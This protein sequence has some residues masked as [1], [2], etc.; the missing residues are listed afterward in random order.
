MATTLRIDSFHDSNILE[1]TELSLDYV[2]ATTAIKVRS[3]AG[4]EVGQPIYV[5][6]LSREGVEKAVIA[7]ITDETTIG[8]TQALKLPHARYEPVTAVLGDSIHI[9]RAA[10]VDGT[11]PA[12]GQFTVLTTRTI[13]PDQISAYYRDSTGSS[14]FWY[15]YTYFNAVTLEETPLQ[16]FDA[17]RGDDFTHYASLSEIRNEAGF[18]HA[19]NLGD[20]DIEQQRRAAETEINA[21]LSG[22]YTVPFSPVPGRVRTLTIQLASALLLAN[23]YGDTSS[24]RQKLKDARAAIDS[25]RLGATV[26][27]DDAGTALSTSESISGFPGDPDRDAPRSFRMSDRF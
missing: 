10:N 7:A 19:T 20:S 21:A 26:L 17:F 5:G 14:A 15:R 1:R 27:I 25:Y 23:A 3:S 11:V 24:S 9:Y 22:A 4:Y 6:Q 12:D 18:K 8:L 2:A 16:A 13:D